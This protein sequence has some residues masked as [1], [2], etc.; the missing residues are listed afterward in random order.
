MFI[1]INLIGKP[2][3]W[4]LKVNLTFIHLQEDYNAVDQ[5]TSQLIYADK[6]YNVRTSD[7]IRSSTF[8]ITTFFK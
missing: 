1:L 7:E 4:S 8:F 2:E 6:I 3:V 5:H